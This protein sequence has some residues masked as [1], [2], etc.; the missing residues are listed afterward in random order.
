[1]LIYITIVLIAIGWKL[2]QNASPARRSISTLTRSSGFFLGQPFLKLEQGLIPMRQFVLDCVSIPSGHHTA[3][4]PTFLSCAI[5]ASVSPSCS[6]IGSQPTRVCQLRFR[7]PWPTKKAIPKTG[8]PLAGTI[9][10]LSWSA[11]VATCRVPS[12][13]LQPSLE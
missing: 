11:E 10:P 5:S 4:L 9:L 7:F 8:G 12:A 2:R 1:M 13:H 6:K 3:I